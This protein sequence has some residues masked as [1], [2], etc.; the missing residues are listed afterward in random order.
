MRL[1]TSP[2]KALMFASSGLVL[3]S[4]ARVVVSV[5]ESYSAVHS[6]RVADEQLMQMCDSGEGLMSADFR[7][8][9]IKKRSERAA[10]ILFKALLHACRTAFQDFVEACSSPTRI[11]LLVLFAVTGMA[12]PIIKVVCNILVT[13]LKERKKRF[14]NLKDGLE[15]DDEEQGEED[16]GQIVV[17]P[18]GILRTNSLRNRVI[19]WS[20]RRER[21]ALKRF[22]EIGEDEAT[23]GSS[24]RHCIMPS[25]S[26]NTHSGMG[27]GRVSSIVDPAWKRR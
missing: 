14:K 2:K 8:L 26:G 21:A 16:C 12:A 13:N 24:S 6:E 15:S 18:D 22:E 7:S 1:L 19:N 9:C 17:I 5:C 4:V 23:G 11:L 20:N 25:F 10:P 3:L 27:I